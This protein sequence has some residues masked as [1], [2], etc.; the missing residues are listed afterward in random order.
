[1]VPRCPWPQLLVITCNICPLSQYKTL[2]NFQ[3]SVLHS[4]LGLIF[5]WTTA[6]ML[7]G[8]TA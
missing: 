7:V 4:A 1:M 3:F 8:G 2:N 6:P 5:R